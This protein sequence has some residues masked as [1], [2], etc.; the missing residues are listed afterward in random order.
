MVQN[1]Y[2]G[3]DITGNAAVP[4]SNQG[5]GITRANNTI[6]AN[7]VISGNQY[8]SGAGFNVVIDALATPGLGVG[9]IVRGNFIGT[10]AAGTG[11]PTG[12]AN[13]AT[14]ILVERG[15]T[16]TI[17]GGT[18]AADRNVISGNSAFSNNS[19][20]AGIA[21]TDAGTTGTVVE[22]NYIGTDVTGN[23]ALANVG[24]GVAI[25][26]GATNNTIGGTA[27]GA[28]NL[29]SG[30]TQ[31]GVLIHGSGTMG[32][33]VAGN[34]IGLNANGSAAIPNDEGVYISGGAQANFVG[35]TAA[36]AGNV[37]S[38][39]HYQGLIFQ[40]AGTDGNVVQGNLFGLD[41]TGAVVIP[42]IDGELIYDGPQNNFL[43][44]TTVAARN[45][46]ASGVQIS[47]GT[48]LTAGNTISGNYIGTN[49]TG[50]AITTDF[51][52]DLNNT[53]G[54]S[55]VNTL[56]G[57]TA[58]AGNLIA[59][60]DYGVVIEEGG[61]FLIEGNT[62]GLNASGTAGIGGG[63]GIGI[64]F[65]STNNVIGGTVAGAGNVISGN[66]ANGVEMDGSGVTNNT[67]VGNLIGINATGTAALGNATGVAVSGGATITRSALPRTGK[68]CSRAGP[69]STSRERRSLRMAPFS[70]RTKLRSPSFA[71]IPSPA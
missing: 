62:I 13:S 51:A 55:A 5:L 22:G 31:S 30:N 69:D 12:E 20:G 35:G 11:V 66:A 3:V 25:D 23:T 2:I 27:A 56:G 14:G 18:S 1:N 16:G 45:I 17:I 71:S 4:N 44:G 61:G 60:T 68:Y 21:I 9:T 42:N 32:N 47:G 65:D 40:D 19:G 53:V 57:T 58:G 39:S 64:V 67:V 59:G 54:T 10:N 34:W 28:D 63:I 43:G 36:G 26:S 38:G 15:A 6:V 52:V 33:T 7:N 29:I 37:I 48:H 41:P 49:A 50:T 24:D 8:Y 46:F 70:L